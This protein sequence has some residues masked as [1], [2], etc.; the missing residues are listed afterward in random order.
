[1]SSANN[2]A[3]KAAQALREAA[4]GLIRHAEELEA[5]VASDSGP[6]T[7]VEAVKPLEPLGPPADADE[8]AM[9]LVALDAAT[10]GRSR[11]EVDAEL[12]AKYPNAEISSLLDRFY[13][14]Q[15]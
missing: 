12:S 5:G 8:A 10:S 6:L 15:P 7:P 13:P 11:D 3:T 9:R 2:P 4:N 14:P 1:M